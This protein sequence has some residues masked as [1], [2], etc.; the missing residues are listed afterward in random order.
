MSTIQIVTRTNKDGPLV[1]DSDNKAYISPKELKDGSLS[2][3]CQQYLTKTNHN[4]T[5]VTKQPNN[6]HICNEL[7]NAQIQMILCHYRI[8]DRSDS[9]K[10][11][12]GRNF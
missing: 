11:S 3:R 12:E 10:T 4:M 1:I 7:T 8:K 2:F 9:E 6:V 5:I